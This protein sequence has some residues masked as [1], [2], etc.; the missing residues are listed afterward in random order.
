M[1]LPSSKFI[2]AG[3]PNIAVTGGVLVAPIATALPTSASGSINSAF[4]ALGYVSEDGIES[5][6]ERKVES[7]KDWNA[8]IIAQL[9]VEH[10]VRFA[11][12]LY[13]VWDKDVLGEVFG[14]DNLTV[15]AATPTSGTLVKVEETGSVLPQRAWI[16]DMLHDTKKLRIVLPNAKI[17]EI[18]ENRF[19]SDELAG[20]RITVEAFKDDAGVKAYR[21]L[22]DGVLSA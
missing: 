17:S 4:K 8:D 21:Y 22:D 6:G 10:S 2:G 12:T 5:K 13:A 1:A 15:T 9:Q 16:F 14:A 20:F 7:V 18:T 3:T 11:L 19:V